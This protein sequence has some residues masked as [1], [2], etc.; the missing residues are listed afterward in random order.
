M[1]P[2]RDTLITTLGVLELRRVGPEAIDLVHGIMC[3]AAAWL[4]QR[5]SGQWGGVP[6]EDFRQFLLTTRLVRDAVYLMEHAGGA[7]GTICIQWDD[8]A[9]WGERGQDGHAGYVHGLAIRRDMAGR[10][11]GGALLRW[12]EN[13]I[14]RSGRPLTR[15]DTMHDNERLCRYY[16]DAGYVDCGVAR[17]N[18]GLTRLFEKRMEQA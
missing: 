13:Q 1:L 8:S 12:A 14:V 11:L 17:T 3:D 6:S 5:G 10:N 16:L 18:W 7:V 2:S 4:K 9:V 15:L